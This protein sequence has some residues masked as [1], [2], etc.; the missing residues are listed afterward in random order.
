M[1]S[2]SASGTNGRTRRRS[3]SIG[4]EIGIARLEIGHHAGWSGTAR[5]GAVA[6][7][8]RATP[9]AG[10]DQVPGDCRIAEHRACVRVEEVQVL[11]V[12]GKLDLLAG[13]G[14]AAAVDGRA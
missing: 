8:R 7:G 2:L 14:R 3:V 11:V 12:D 1:G 5:R 9:S 6:D 10:A 13:P 4:S